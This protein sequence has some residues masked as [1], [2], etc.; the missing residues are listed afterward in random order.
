MESLKDPKRT[1]ILQVVAGG[2]FTAPR[3]VNDY[4][5]AKL[6]G[7]HSCL[8]LATIFSTF[9]RPL[10]KQELD[11]ALLVTVATLKKVIAIKKPLHAVFCCSALGEFVTD[12]LGDEHN[13]KQNTQQRR[14]FK[15]IKGNNT[16]AVNRT[17]ADPHFE[18]NLDLRGQ[19]SRAR[20]QAYLKPTGPSSHSAVRRWF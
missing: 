6:G 17:A 20:G 19:G 4:C 1:V 3:I 2:E 10:R 18:I 8:N 15:M 9:T 12:S 16:R 11:G 5:R 14:Q 7:L 13:R